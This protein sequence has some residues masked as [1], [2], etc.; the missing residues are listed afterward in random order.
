MERI[1]VLEV[2]KPQGLKGEIK[3]RLLARS[4]SDLNVTDLKLG[5]QKVTIDSIRELGGFVY[6]KFNEINS[7][8]EA[9]KFRGKFLSAPKE[10]LTLD[11]GEY[12]LED[13]INK[14][15][16][17]EDGGC[18]G[19]LTDVQNFGSADVMF[20]LTPKGKE[21]LFSNVEGVIIEVA[22]EKIIINKKKFDE[23]SV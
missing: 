21:V 23:V 4:L 12:F 14:Q 13:L 9:E 3:F 6:I 20:V 15:I 10:E 16:F 8:L 7:V 1:N 2:L 19:T 5:D 22:D 18:L 17:F 11:E